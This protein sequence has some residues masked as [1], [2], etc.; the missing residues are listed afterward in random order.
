MALLKY[1]YSINNLVI[2]LK[3]AQ[4]G[5]Q[6][7]NEREIISQ[8][9]PNAFYYTLAPTIL[10][11]NRKTLQEKLRIKYIL[12]SYSSG[13]TNGSLSVLDKYKH[14][15]KYNFCRF[16][17]YIMPPNIYKKKPFFHAFELIPL[18]YLYIIYK[19]IKSKNPIYIYMRLIKVN[20]KSSLNL[21]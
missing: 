9:S 19:L 18:T 5:G 15:F 16:H 17:S 1:N 3:S 6:L 2:C 10:H 8:Q 7:T 14:K 11:L 21:Y 4:I 12:K 20:N 13:K